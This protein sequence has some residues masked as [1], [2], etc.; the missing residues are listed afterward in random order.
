MRKEIASKT[1]IEIRLTPEEKELI[2][3]YCE[4]KNITVSDFVRNACYKI[5]NQEEK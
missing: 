3:K 2:K 1:K 4:S 5:F